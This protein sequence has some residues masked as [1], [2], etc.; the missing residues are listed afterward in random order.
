MTARN[1]FTTVLMLCSLMLITL[2]TDLTA[3]GLLGRARRAVTE[4]VAGAV[5]DGVMG[6]GSGGSSE[7]RAPETAGTAEVPAARQSTYLLT[8]DAGV[9]DRLEQAMRAEITFFDEWLA[10]ED[11]FMTCQ[12]TLYTDPD[13]MDEL[14]DLSDEFTRAMET[15]GSDGDRTMR[16]SEAYRAGIDAVV[17]RRCG[18]SQTAFAERQATASDDALAAALQ[19]GGFTDQQ[20]SVLKERLVPFCAAGGNSDRIAG[21]EGKHFYVYQAIEVEALSS[22]CSTLAPLAQRAI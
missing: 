6:G 18:I 11:R 5:A 21:P 2:A 9:L 8:M 7:S 20:Y 1:G 15:A 12:G 10:L 19:A 14:Q 22:R 17:E 3:Q 4:T 13:S 16:A